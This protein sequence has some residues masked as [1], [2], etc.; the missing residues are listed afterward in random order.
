MS[1]VEV[2]DYFYMIFSMYTLVP[3]TLDPAASSI[4]KARLSTPCYYYI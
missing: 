1:Q 2:K 3:H 4:L